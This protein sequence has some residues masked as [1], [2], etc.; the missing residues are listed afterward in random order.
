MTS[1]PIATQY[2]KAHFN[3]A[4]FIGDAWFADATFTGSTSFNYATFT[5]DA[6]FD[7]A[8]FTGDDIARF[9]E[10]VLV[11]TTS[12]RE[13]T[14]ADTASFERAT[15]PSTRFIDPRTPSPWTDFIAARFALD[16]PPRSG[17]VRVAANRETGDEVSN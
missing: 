5:G 4:T 17:G 16:V 14:F 6:R 3:H 1:T 8:T 2:R 10:T 13:A 12:F 15:L 9:L 11:G 7:S